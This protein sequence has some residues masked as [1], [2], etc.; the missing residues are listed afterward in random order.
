MMRRL[1]RVHHS[2]ELALDQFT[3][4]NTAYFV[5]KKTV[6]VKR[7][8]AVNTDQFSKCFS[9]TATDAIISESVAC[10]DDILSKWLGVKES[11]R[12][13]R[14]NHISFRDYFAVARNWFDQIKLKQMATHFWSPLFELSDHFCAES[15]STF[16]SRRF[17]VMQQ[18]YQRY[19]S[20]LVLDKLIM[21]KIKFPN[22]REMPLVPTLIKVALFQILG[23]VTISSK[24]KGDDVRGRILES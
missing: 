19:L 6:H 4:Q 1:Q 18:Q 7:M 14:T 8:A 2:V 12:L 5:D 17:R 16:F 11:K 10:L 22:A 15:A 9:S 13:Q 24:S 23:D 21:C 20:L 3:Q